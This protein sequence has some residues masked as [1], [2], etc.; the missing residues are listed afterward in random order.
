MTWI[1]RSGYWATT[2]FMKA[3][4][5]DAS[6]PFYNDIPVILPVANFQRGE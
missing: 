4:K 1:S 3:Q 6:P 5:L 2:W